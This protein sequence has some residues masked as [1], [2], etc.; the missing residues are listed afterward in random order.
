MDLVLVEVH[1]MC[2]GRGPLIIRHL[3]VLPKL[4]HTTGVLPLNSAESPSFVDAALAAPGLTLRLDLGARVKRATSRPYRKL[5][6]LTV[7][8]DCGLSLVPTLRC[9]GRHQCHSLTLQMQGSPS[10]GRTLYS[11]VAH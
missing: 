3:D 1:E 2:G 8:S 10:C 4:P 5:V 9:Q 7:L 11:P 6:P